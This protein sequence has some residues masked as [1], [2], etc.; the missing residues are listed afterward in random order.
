MDFQI[1]ILDQL[2]LSPLSQIQVRLGKDVFKTLVVC[3]DLT[4]VPNKIMPPNLEG[5][6]HS[7]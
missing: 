7:Y 4:L 1:I 2:Q 3:V 5:V 6:D